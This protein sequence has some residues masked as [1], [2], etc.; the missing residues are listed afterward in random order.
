MF[1]KYLWVMLFTT[2]AFVLNDAKAK[3][4]VN[5]TPALS[6][7][8]IA[9]SSY[10]HSVNFRTLPTNVQAAPKNGNCINI[11]FSCGVTGTICGY[12]IFNVVALIEAIFVIDEMLCPY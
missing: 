12:L 4:T 10:V 8:K 1:M 3:T 5:S 6:F 11:P 7:I 9:K 2:M